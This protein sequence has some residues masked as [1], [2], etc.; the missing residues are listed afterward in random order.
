MPRWRFAILV[1]QAKRLALMSSGERSAWGCSMPAKRGGH[2]VQRRYAAESRH[3]TKIATRIRVLKQA[4]AK[5]TQAVRGSGQVERARD[6]VSPQP[7]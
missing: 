7:T 5:K 1:G 2:A 6:Q 4:R 3:P